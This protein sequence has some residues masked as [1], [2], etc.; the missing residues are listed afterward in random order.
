MTK[1]QAEQIWA[2]F[3]GSQT[4]EEFTAIY[5]ERGIGDHEEMARGYIASLSEMFPY[6][7]HAPAELERAL[8][9]ILYMLETEG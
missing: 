3:V 4:A 8:Q 7:D 2:E 1:C 5:R 9:G 6:A